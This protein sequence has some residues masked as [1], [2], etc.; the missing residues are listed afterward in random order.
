MEIVQNLLEMNNVNPLVKNECLNLLNLVLSQNYFLFDRKYYSSDEGLIMGNPLSPLL[1]E[2]F[3][4]DLEQRISQND[5][6]SKFI[7]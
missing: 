4:D 5:S 2:I 1:A 6:F 7:Y 3:M